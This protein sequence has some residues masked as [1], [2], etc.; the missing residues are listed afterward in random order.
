MLADDEEELKV[1]E[2]MFKDVKFFVVGDIDPKVPGHPFRSFPPY[3]SS[4]PTPFGGGALWN[5]PATTR[6]LEARAASRGKGGS[7]GERALEGP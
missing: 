5:R 4:S 3:P 7:G 1:P 2:E 6:G